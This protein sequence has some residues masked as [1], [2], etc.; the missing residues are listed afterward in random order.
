MIR[1]SRA[2]SALLVVLAGMALPALAEA[3]TTT[4]TTSLTTTPTTTQA[5]TEGPTQAPGVGSY[6]LG[7]T[8]IE[9]ERGP[10]IDDIEFVGS[11]YHALCHLNYWAAPGRRVQRCTQRRD[12]PV[13][14]VCDL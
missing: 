13:S 7:R 2:L 10:C 9:N 1:A 3:A 4:L 14:A 5:T 8:V 6:M 12:F 11:S